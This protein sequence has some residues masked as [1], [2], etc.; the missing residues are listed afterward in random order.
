MSTQGFRLQLP[1]WDQRDLRGRREVW[2]VL[3]ANQRGGRQYGRRQRVT[4]FVIS[5]VATLAKQARIPPSAHLTVELVWVPEHAN[6]RRDADNLWPLLKVVCDALARGPIKR[7][8]HG[9]GLDLVPDDTPE[10]MTKL[11]P[12]IAT[13][14]EHEPGLWLHLTATPAPSPDRE[15]SSP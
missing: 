3:H 4:N 15:T 8:R 6:R 1:R 11:A 12:R 2:D 7:A 13:P 9:P 14:A 10:Y 5:T